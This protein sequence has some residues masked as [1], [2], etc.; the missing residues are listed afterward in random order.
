MAKKEVVLYPPN[1]G[2]EGVITHP[3]NYKEMIKNGWKE[4]PSN[5]KEQKQETKKSKEK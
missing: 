5:I 3:S 1:G 4:K 2:D